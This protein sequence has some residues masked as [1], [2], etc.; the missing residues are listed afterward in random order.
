[1]KKLLSV[2]LLA[3]AVTAAPIVSAHGG[4]EP[5]H[6]GV[7]AVA[8]DLVFELTSDAKGAVIYVD[9]HG[10]PFPT[11]AISGKLTV[12]AAGKK[13]E[14]E[15]K[16]LGENQLQAQGIKLSRGATAVAVL[17]TGDKKPLTV[18]FKVK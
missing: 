6:G 8:H 4:G 14:A 5:K 10:E 12:L 7:V 3:A 15:L 11:Q 16:P 1:M 9:D 18:R 2:L 13:T 17:Q